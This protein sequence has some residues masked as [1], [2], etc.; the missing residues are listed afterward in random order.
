MSRSQRPFYTRL[1]SLGMS[2]VMLSAGMAGSAGSATASSLGFEERVACEQAIQEVYYSHRSWPQDSAKPP[3]QVAVSREQ[4]EA[5]VRASEDKARLLDERWGYRINAAQLQAEIERMAAKSRWPDRLG[6]LW[7]ALGNDSLLI[8]ECLARPLL[9]ERRIRSFY[10]ADH[11][12]HSA[13][14]EKAEAEL[15]AA[16]DAWTLDGM[17]G[18]VERVELRRERAKS[19]DVATAPSVRLLDDAE[20]EAQALRLNLDRRIEPSAKARF[21][22]LQENDEA[23]WAEA[24]LDAKADHI[25]LTVVHWPKRSFADWFLE[26]RAAL[27]A[28]QPREPVKMANNI[29]SLPKL[30]TA[31]CTDD[32]WSLIQPEGRKQH[33]AVWTGSEMIVWGGRNDEGLLRSG[34]RYDPVTDTWTSVETAGAPSARDFHTAVWTGARMIVWGGM[35]DLVAVPQGH[36]YNPVDDSWSPIS[37]VGAPAARWAHTAVWAEE[38]S[39][40]LVWGGRTGCST[41]ACTDTGTGGAYDPSTNSW[42][43]LPAGPSARYRHTANWTAAGMMVWGGRSNSEGYIGNGSVLQKSG[44]DWVWNDL[45]DADAPSPR[46]DHTAVWTGLQLII[47]GGRNTNG[48][49]ADGARFAILGWLPISEVDAPPGLVGS[50]ATWTGSEMVVWG[51]ETASGTLSNGFYRYRADSDDWLFTVSLLSRRRDHTAVWNGTRLLVWGGETALG[52]SEAGVALTPATATTAAISGHLQPSGRID[53]SAVWTGGEMIVWGGTTSLG[54][55]STGG[56]Y[57]PAT[58]T[59]T[60]TETVGSPSARSRHTALWTGSE[61]V[62]W[63]GLG[64]GVART[65]GGRYDP[66]ADTW[67]PTQTSGAPPSRFQHTA[68][69]TGSQMIVWGGRTNSQLRGD[70]GTYIPSLDSWFPLAAGGAPSPRYQHS[71]AWTGTTMIVWGGTDSLDTDADPLG[72][73]AIYDLGTETWLPMAAAGARKQHTATWSGSEMLVYGYDEGLTHSGHR[74]DPGTDAWSPIAGSDGSDYRRH[75]HGATWT[76]NELI[77]W[78]GDSGLT[79]LVRY[80]PGTETLSLGNASGPTS[81]RTGFTT[82]WTDREMLVWGGFIESGGGLPSRLSNGGGTY[83]ARIDRIFHHRF[84]N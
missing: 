12:L 74:Y 73:G 13:V 76:G 61:M 64:G 46:A 21:A 70:G 38:E 35:V 15:Q 11:E 44:S 43:S 34:G 22:Q 39:V 7:A 49:L 20:F 55:T 63:A 24:V 56:R 78:G 27:P 75:R 80:H 6:E 84:E 40:M 32:T 25:S 53:H 3:F 33:T 67:V 4:I 47:W 45:P 28:A 65:D 54:R 60:H 18:Q 82:I 1:R 48:P 50:T 10:Q 16:D 59:W 14:R 83:C 26:A 42:S 9:V 71:A 17:S 41:F 66:I 36:S 52:A 30:G 29:F 58:D 37:S 68:L 51:G 8:A 72:N 79:G 2:F 57:D 62:V 5:R 77:L 19:G 69:W 31:G 23:F 81:R